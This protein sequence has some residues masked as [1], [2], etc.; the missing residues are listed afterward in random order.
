[1]KGLSNVVES[2]QNEIRLLREENQTLTKLISEQRTLLDSMKADS[3]SNGDSSA[4]MNVSQEPQ[5]SSQK[6]DKPCEDA[7]SINLDQCNKTLLIGDSII[8][9]INVRGLID[10]VDVKCIRGA[11]TSVINDELK[12]MDIAVYETVIVHSGTNDCT[13]DHKLREGTNAYKDLINDMKERAPDTTLIL[14]TVCPRTDS[15]QANK[16]VTTFNKEIRKYAAKDNIKLIDNEQLSDVKD[17]LDSRGLHL[18]TVGTKHLLRNINKVCAITVKP[19]KE[20]K[21]SRSKSTQANFSTSSSTQPATR[22]NSA[23]VQHHSRP[24]HSRGSAFAPNQPRQRTR[25]FEPQ[26]STLTP[27]QS[28]RR[29]QFV[30]RGSQ[31]RN[32]DN[33]RCF[34]CGEQNHVK[35]NCRH[36]KAISCHSCG[37]LGH[38]ASMCFN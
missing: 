17:T 29:R 12:D 25:Q 33:K 14:S 2:Q 5:N 7:P 6:D 16:R 38:K 27:N 8:R 35:R 15:K 19:V 26:S 31:E 22:V 20:T 32:V 34:F 9:D 21:Q 37:Q 3:T 1:M 36:G 13:S 18:S 10:T 23:P 30:S 11:R 28:S 24:R 4:I